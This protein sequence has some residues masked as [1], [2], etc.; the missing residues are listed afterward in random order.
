MEHLA[1]AIR[2]NPSI[3]DRVI[4]QREIQ[5]SLYADDLL[6]YISNPNMAFPTLMHKLKIFGQR[7][8]F[9]VNMHKMEGLDVV[10]LFPIYL[11]N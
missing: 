8:N 1:N 7:T 5:L 3:Q 11:E 6:L 2:S 9:R 10:G 4:G